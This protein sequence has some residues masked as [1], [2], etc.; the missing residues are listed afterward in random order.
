MDRRDFAYDLP[1]ELIAQAPLPERSASRLLVLDGAT[2]RIED[3]R[4][5]DIAELL[6]AGD[7]LVLNDTR[8]LP[9]RLH[10]RKATGGRVE[11]LLERVLGPRRAL[12]QLR[13]SRSPKAGAILELPGGARAV[14][15]GRAGELF[16]LELDR[17]VEPYLAAHGEVPLP[18]YIERVPADED[19]ERYQTVFARASGAVAAPTAGLH[20][21]EALLARL[22]ERGVERGFLTLHVGAG[23]FAPVRTEQ[24]EAHRLHPEWVRVSAELCERIAAARRRGGRI[25]AVGTTA[26]R[27]LETA[28]QKGR[29]EPYE[30]ETD[31]F[32]Y[33]GFEF[34]LV[35][36]LV[37]NF[38][39]PESSLL[40]LVAAFAGRERTLAAYRHAVAERYRFFSYGDAMFV[41]PADDARAGDARPDAPG[42]TR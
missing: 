24:V 14:V 22:A 38:H 5:A 19:R 3:R 32:I 8:V 12:V 30:G 1:P 34:R 11:I 16:D 21:D 10:G 36:A 33:P 42:E 41:T 27:A 37:T 6:R 40:M 20:F 39:L 17:D 29:L 13:A 25:V 28:A 15:A 2:G 18:P 7:L 26:V 4:F 23:T 9:A 35:D 31:L